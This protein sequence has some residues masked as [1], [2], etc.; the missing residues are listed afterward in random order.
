M[1]D[2]R[3]SEAIVTNRDFLESTQELSNTEEQ[4]PESNLT[5]QEFLDAM[6]ALREAQRV[7]EAARTRVWQAAKTYK[8]SRGDG[9]LYSTW[10]YVREVQENPSDPTTLIMLQAEARRLF[11]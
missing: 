2:E 7:F 6:L 10:L 9:V 3:M 8:P 1:S 11:P 4:P 5:A